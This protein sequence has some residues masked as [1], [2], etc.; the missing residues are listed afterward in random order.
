MKVLVVG[1]GVFGSWTAK[2]LA[3]DGHPVTLLDAY[4]PANGRASSAD[5]S[6]VIRAGYGAEEIYSRWARQSLADWQWLCDASGQSLLARTGALFMGAPADAYVLDTHRTLARLGLAV[7]LLEPSQLQQ[8]F[9]HIAVEHLG[10]TLLER[11]AGVI[12]ARA[13]VQALVDVIAR[14][15]VTYLQAQIE[16][17]DEN[18]ATLR[19]RGG[20]GSEFA[21]D[22]C[23]FACGP[24]LPTV[25]P[26][27]VGAR[28]R[29]TRQE[30]LYFGAP[31]GEARFSA[32]QLPVWIDFTAGLYGI[33][34]LDA[35]GVKVGID[36]HGPPIDPD[37]L[38][39]LLES[40]VVETTRQWLGRR[41]PAL[42]RAPLVDAR[43]CQYENT[44]S[45]DFIID[46]HPA[47][48]TC[49]IVGGG[50]G[51]GFKHGPAVGRHVAALIAGTE[52]VQ[53]RFSLATKETR[54]ARAVY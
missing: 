2:C 50:S 27:A 53:E 42:S 13:A 4:G 48:P 33:P 41:F 11:D 28:V 26:G 15:G 52:Q 24:W 5:H 47:W 54:A 34:D 38:D 36:R 30:V 12:R 46:R 49:W 16:R 32:A 25:L 10:L 8:R 45:G 23:V 22:A 51:H 40:E 35:C 31:P 29:A 43:V 7:E 9:P 17:V 44:S 20:D 1:A 37:Q 18:A 3:D 21:A 39:R 19:V 6:R 14:S